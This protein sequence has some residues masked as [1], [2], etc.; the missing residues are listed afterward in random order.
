[1]NVYLT[2]KK[3]GIY[4]LVF[5]TFLLF[6][7]ITSPG[8]TPYDYFTRLAAAF[9]QG[10]TYLTENP[11][12]LS[13]L[14]PAGQSRFYVPYPSMPAI[15]AMPFVYLFKNNFH[16]EYLAHLLGAGMVILTIK[17]SLLIKKN[18]KLAIWSG[19]LVGMGSI[20]WFLSSV[21]SS[22]YLGQIT[23]AF[24]L[25]AALVEALGKK[26]LI[27]IGIFLG[28]AYLARYHAILSLPFFLFLLKPKLKKLST[29]SYLGFSFFIFFLFDAIYNFRRFGVF[30]NKGYLL[31]PGIMEEPWFSKGLMHP[32]YIIGNLKVAF[33]SLP[34]FQKSFP[35]LK[36]SWGGLSILLTTPA[37]IF[38]LTSK[39]K[40]RVNQF[41]WLSVILIFGFVAMHGSSGFAQFGYR[42]AV[43]FYPFLIFLT[44]KGVARTGLKKIHW[45]LLFAGVIVNLWGVLWINKFGWVGF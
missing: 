15:L 37:F 9:L 41:A 18:T 44:I 23:A 19:I 32:S 42:F 11:S 21:G 24:F 16:Q 30:W 38:S 20:I 36:P 17:M 35:Y 26:R 34:I 2:N 28:A 12:W 29:W 25:L 6:Y 1:M 3:I 14:I 7:F 39:F 33:L 10:K 13:E 27:H 8:N 4:L 31:I 5:S 43:D 45:L 40:E 22:W